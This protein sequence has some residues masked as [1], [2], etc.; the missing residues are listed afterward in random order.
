VGLPLV[1]EDVLHM[2]IAAFEV[3]IVVRAQ[4]KHSDH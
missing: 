1:L 2:T 4:D 3:H